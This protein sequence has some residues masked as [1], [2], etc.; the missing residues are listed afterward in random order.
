VSTTAAVGFDIDGSTQLAYAALTSPLGGAS[1]FYGVNLAT[2]GVTLTG[3]VGHA[4]PLVGI[5]VH[6]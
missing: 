5:A 2:G 6:P 4:V 1:R 3:T